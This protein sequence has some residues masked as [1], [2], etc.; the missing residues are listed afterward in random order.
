MI[1]SKAEVVMPGIFYDPTRRTL[2]RV[3]ERPEDGWLLVTHDVAASSNRC[4]RIMREWL[5]SADL[6][7]ID[8]RIYTAG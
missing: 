4:R 5:P 6:F 2:H 1:E 7:A 3:D 8:W